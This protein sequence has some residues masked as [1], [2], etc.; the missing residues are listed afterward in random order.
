M[1]YALPAG[2]RP[3]PQMTAD[4]H[5]FAAFELD[6]EGRVLRLEGREIPLQPRVFDL[7]LYLVSTG[8]GW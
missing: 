8:I 2:R 6:G 5:R 1:G 7:L 3:A 4:I